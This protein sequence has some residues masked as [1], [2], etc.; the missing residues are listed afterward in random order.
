MPF[1]TAPLFI[2]FPI[3]IEFPELSYFLIFIVS[4]IFYHVLNS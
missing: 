1:S 4:Q 2:T 3:N